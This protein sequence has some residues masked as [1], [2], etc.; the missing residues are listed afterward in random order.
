[1]AEISA[2]LRM[3]NVKTSIVSRIPGHRLVSPRV[4]WHAVAT[5]CDLAG[6]VADLLLPRLPGRL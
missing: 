6:H 4:L 3:Y 1:M 2:E 5:A